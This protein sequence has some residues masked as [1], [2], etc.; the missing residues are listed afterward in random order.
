MLNIWRHTTRIRLPLTVLN[1]QCNAVTRHMST[2]IRSDSLE[3][4]DAPILRIIQCR[5]N[6]RAR[7]LSEVCLLSV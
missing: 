5:F 4:D 3:L 1:K 6:E 7:L 2:S